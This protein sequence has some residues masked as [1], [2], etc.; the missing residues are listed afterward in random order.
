M[1]A[2]VLS[3]D[4]KWSGVIQPHTRPVLACA[5]RTHE[6]S[7]MPEW[8]SGALK[9]GIR[10]ANPAGGPVGGR[11]RAQAY[12]HRDSHTPRRLE[13][14]SRG[15]SRPQRMGRCGGRPGHLDGA[16]PRLP[17]CR[18]PSR[19]LR[20]VRTKLGHARPG[21]RA[22]RTLHAATRIQRL[23][24]GIS[25]PGRHA[26]PHVA[27]RSTLGR[28][29]RPR[30]GSRSAAPPGASRARARVAASGPVYQGG[31]PGDPRAALSEGDRSRRGWTSA[32]RRPQS[33]PCHPRRPPP[34]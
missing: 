12:P 23:H 17:H 27:A 33:R 18:R 31:T 11:T 15:R 24:V 3:I 30:P 28:H 5:P 8:Q 6:V 16:R 19:R 13:P 26:D 34:Q 9:F 10:E 1:S 21:C 29:D 22:T 7:A 14:R 20:R 4:R 32:D 2:P 25:R